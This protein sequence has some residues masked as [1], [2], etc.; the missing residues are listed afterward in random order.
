MTLIIIP[1]KLALILVKDHLFDEAI[2]QFLTFYLY[3]LQKCIIRD[4]CGKLIELC[5][6]FGGDEKK[7]IKLRSPGATHQK[8]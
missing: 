5:I 7:R 4:Y 8:R 6:F 2:N 3:E 1:L